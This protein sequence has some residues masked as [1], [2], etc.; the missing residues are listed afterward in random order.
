MARNPAG[1]RYI[2][3]KQDQTLR[4]VVATGSRVR[5]AAGDRGQDPLFRQ[6][7]TSE[8]SANS[9]SDG[10]YAM[11]LGPLRRFPGGI[12]GKQRARSLPVVGQAERPPSPP[13]RRAAPVNPALRHASPTPGD[14]RC[15]EA[16]VDSLAAARSSVA[17]GDP[18]APA[19]RR[20][21]LISSIT[22]Y[23]ASVPSPGPAHMSIMRTRPGGAVRGR[24][25]PG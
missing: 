15:L 3:D 5:G 2:L 6:A 11:R 14:L 1:R 18:L 13:C 9:R 21:R 4:R 16:D 20:Q 7:P 23:D 12:I 17:A 8:S 22:R 10:H 25:R 19:G 24:K